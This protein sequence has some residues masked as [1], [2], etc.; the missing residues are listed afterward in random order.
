MLVKPFA[1]QVAGYAQEVQCDG[2]G[3]IG[4]HKIPSA[5]NVRL[6]GSDH[7]FSLAEIELDFLGGC[8]CPCGITLVIRQDSEP[9]IA[10][11]DRLP[12][13]PVGAATP[14]ILAW[15]DGLVESGAYCGKGR[16]MD[17][18]GSMDYHREAK[19]SHWQPL[20]AGPANQ[21]ATKWPN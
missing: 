21:G 2:A 11:G 18:E 13:E 8:G 3:R 16:F 6:E 10:V 15:D 7:D 4:S 9:W 20:P 14:L 5:V 1:E 12:D 19:V 17:A